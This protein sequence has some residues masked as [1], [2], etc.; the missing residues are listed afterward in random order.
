MQQT[1]QTKAQLL[2]QLLAERERIIEEKERTIK[3]LMEK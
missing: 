1:Q 2:E 3:I